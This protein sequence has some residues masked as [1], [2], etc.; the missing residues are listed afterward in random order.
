MNNV[1]SLRF[2]KE[3]INQTDTNQELFRL[4]TSGG[5]I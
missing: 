3:K 5:S 4:M 1:E 2:M